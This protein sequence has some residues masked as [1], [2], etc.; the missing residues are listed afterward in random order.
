MHESMV[1][2]F[3]KRIERRRGGGRRGFVQRGVVVGLDRREWV[4]LPVVVDFRDLL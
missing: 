2:W 1:V 3:G 4:V